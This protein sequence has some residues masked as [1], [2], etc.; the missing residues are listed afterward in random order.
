VSALTPRKAAFS[1]FFANWPPGRLHFTAHSHPPWPD[2]SFAAHQQA[3]IDASRCL[4]AKWGEVVF[5]ET[6]PRAQRHLARLLKL[7]DSKTICFAPNTH[8]FLM[9]LL[10]GIPH[11]PVRILT[12]DSEFLSF[13][14]QIAR[15]E[16]SGHA[17]VERVAAEPYESFSERFVQAAN[18]QP[19][20]F[21]YLSQ[22]F[23]NSGYRVADFNSLVTAVR[24]RDVP[25][26]IDGY[27]GFMAVP[28]DLSA[29]AARAFYLAGG[30]KYAM[31]GEGVCYLHCPPGYIPRPL[32][33]GWYA[34]FTAPQGRTDEV[35]YSSDGQ[36][37]FGATFDPSG[38]YRFN[39]VMDWLVTEG[40][41][42]ERLH[43]HAWA[44][45][46]MFLEGVMKRPPPSFA[47]A[48]LLP[49]GPQ[50]R[51][52]FLTFRHPHA[53]EFCKRLQAQQVVTDNR[54]DRLR[55]GFGIYQDADDVGD[56]VRR[57]AAALD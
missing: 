35:T 4:G 9:R 10:S 12:T 21:I 6:L 5:S 36:R 37:F 17:Q 42:P 46:A 13:S 48:E 54:G 34:G 19:Y 2:V 52:N 25:L 55:I 14:R 33:T 32:D 51:G 3:W 1:R 20:D 11:G 53:A 23:F 49:S 40:L 16:E 22:V 26:V 38:L 31:S 56:L 15:L 30:S 44:L 45:Q 7:P 39:A 18:R 50:P 27:H 29:I 28:T 47:E 41:T 57:F 8:E 43:A 24:D